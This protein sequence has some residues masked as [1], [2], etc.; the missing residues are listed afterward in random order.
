[1]FLFF[2]SEASDKSWKSIA[3][4]LNDTSVKNTP[5]EVNNLCD[6][7]LELPNDSLAQLREVLFHSENSEIKDGCEST[8]VDNNLRSFAFDEVP[9]SDQVKVEI[10][11]IADGET[12]MCN[13]VS[14]INHFDSV[15][16]ENMRLEVD[17]CD[18]NLTTDQTTR[19]TEA[20]QDDII[21]GIKRQT[22]R[23]YPYIINSNKNITEKVNEMTVNF[24]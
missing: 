23:S 5:C 11:G 16:D 20:D 18:N 14:L 24:Y 10:P 2:F 17:S 22:L 13:L 7:L 4:S 6:H 21:R 9:I 1:M 19:T 12:V 3:L 8:D 15:G